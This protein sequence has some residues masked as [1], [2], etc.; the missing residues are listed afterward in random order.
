MPRFASLGLGFVFLFAGTIGCFM[1]AGNQPGALFFLVPALAMLLIPVGCST[2]AFGA[3]GPLVSLIEYT[4]EGDR[5]LR[6]L[7]RYLAPVRG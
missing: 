2:L 3:G 7:H 1:L 5:V 4:A 6:E